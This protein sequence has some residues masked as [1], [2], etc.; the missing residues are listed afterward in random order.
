MSIGL[1]TRS[2]LHRN[3][4]T[5]H[6]IRDT[7]LHDTRTTNH[8]S[9]SFDELGLPGLREQR[10]REKIDR[11]W[12]R[13]WRVAMWAILLAAFFAAGYN[14]RLNVT[15]AK[16]RAEVVQDM[17]WTRIAMTIPQGKRKC[18]V[19]WHEGCLVCIHRAL[20]GASV[21]SSHC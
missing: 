4:D 20:G 18:A 11:W 9:P 8:E 12:R 13:V 1:R 19:E 14:T 3:R 2:L 10:R 5:W 15:E 21:K 6:V 16:R 7:E 17:G